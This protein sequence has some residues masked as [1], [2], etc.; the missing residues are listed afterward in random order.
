MEKKIISIR[1][2]NVSE[3]AFE[4]KKVRSPIDKIQENE[5]SG[6]DEWDSDRSYSPN[7]HRATSSPQLYVRDTNIDD[8]KRRTM[9]FSGPFSPL[10]NKSEPIQRLIGMKDSEKVIE[11]LDSMNLSEEDRNSLLIEKSVFTRDA[12]SY[13]NYIKATT[14]GER[15][16]NNILLDKAKSTENYRRYC[17]YI[18]ATTEEDNE[19]R[20]LIL[21]K[22][23][24]SK[25]IP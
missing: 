5:V 23:S 1:G 14:F 13:V 25:V 18:N 10:R 6:Y 2:S 8:V 16:T 9:S 24:T 21:S 17:I 11:A 12:V 20:R 4:T 19:K 15:D 22:Q 3:R 7:R